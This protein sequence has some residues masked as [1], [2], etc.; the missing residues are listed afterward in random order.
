MKISDWPVYFK[1]RIM[2]GDLESNVGIVTLWTPRELIVKDI[3]KDAFAA[4]GQ[5]YTKR[6]VDYIFRNILA[7]PR[8]RYLVVCGVERTG[9][10]ET[11]L[12]FETFDKEV[13]K[14][15]KKLKTSVQVIDRRGETSGSNLLSVLNNLKPLPPFGEPV[16]LPPGTHRVFEEL[17]TNLSTVTIRRQTIGEAWIEILRHL[18]KFGVKS[19]AVHHYFNRKVGDFRELLNLTV[20]VENEDHESPKLFDFFPFGD[21]DLDKYFES[22]FKKE[23]GSEPYTYGER[24]FDYEGLDQVEKMVEKLKRFPFD[25]GALAVLWQPKIDNFPQRKPW[26][27]PCLTLIQGQ[28]LKGKLYLTSYFRSHDM[29]GGWP[30]N[31]FALRKLQGQIA[32]RVGLELGSLVTISGLAHLYEHDFAEAQRIVS[33]N[34]KLYCEWDPRGNFAIRVEGGLIKVEHLSPDG[35]FLQKFEG[36]TAA[37]V[38]QKLDQ[39]LAVSLL[40]HAFDLGCELQKAEVALKLGM[41]YNQDQPLNL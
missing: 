26:R 25:K 23:R 17:P 11:L 38:C 36:K 19:E 34:D 21:D 2:V 14:Y 18:L 8:I 1:E 20:V 9:S 12:G 22:F 31:A 40:S 13:K 41:E 24:L 30:F 37:E 16:V 7:N 32:E 6:G 28:T 3:P 15:Q 5:L 4:A 33:E 10:G 29:F 27:T 39:A 35:I